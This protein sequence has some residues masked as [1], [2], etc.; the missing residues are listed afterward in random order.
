MEYK[1]D[2]RKKRGSI[3]SQIGMF[4]NQGHWTV[5]VL[6]QETNSQRPNHGAAL[7]QLCELGQGASDFFSSKK[8]K[9]GLEDN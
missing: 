4:Y 7:N 5:E 8:R 1:T 9:D 6:N 2:E 3:T